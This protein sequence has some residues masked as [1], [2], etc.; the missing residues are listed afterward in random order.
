MG[1]DSNQEEKWEFGSLEWSQYASETGVRLL[2]EANLDLSKFN[3]GFSEEYTHAPERLLGGREKA[4][5]QFMITDGKISGSEVITE[6]CLALPGFHVSVPWAMIAHASA[7]LYD[8]QGQG[9]RGKDA[10]AL[11]AEL[12]AA[13]YG[14]KK[15]AEQAVA[16]MMDEHWRSVVHPDRVEGIRAFTEGREPTFPDPDF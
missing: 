16:I 1:N 13:G 12:E 7:V 5:F 9:E 3:W 10:A 4:G 15:P 8:L 14:V 2:K 6:E 11:E